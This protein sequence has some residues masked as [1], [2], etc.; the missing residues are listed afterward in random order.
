MSIL[1][2]K[3]VPV[4]PRR[5]FQR[6]AQHGWCNESEVREVLGPK[7][8][9]DDRVHIGSALAAIGRKIGLIEE[10]SAALERGLGKASAE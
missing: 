9:P 10:E 2:V 3:S 4:K 1:A 8:K 6:L 7:V 5:T